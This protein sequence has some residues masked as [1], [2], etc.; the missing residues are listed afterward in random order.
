MVL[1]DPERHYCDDCLHERREDTVAIFAST[2][3]AALARGRAEGHDPAHGGDAGAKRAT[4][5]RA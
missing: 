5:Q 4:R 1:E 2:G 3:P